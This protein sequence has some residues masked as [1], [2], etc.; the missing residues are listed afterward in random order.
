MFS[1]NRIIRRRTRLTTAAFTE[2]I[3]EVD[4]SNNF[5]PRLGRRRTTSRRRTGIHVLHS[6]SHKLAVFLFEQ[7]IRSREEARIRCPRIIPPTLGTQTT[8]CKPLL[9][10]CQICS[11]HLCAKYI[12]KR[13]SEH[14]SS[15]FMA[16]LLRNRAFQRGVASL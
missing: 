9:T 13:K 11:F 1:R 16:T 15:P 10:R 6:Q 7:V 4:A 2:N 12:G 14:P 5:L 3:D 8:T